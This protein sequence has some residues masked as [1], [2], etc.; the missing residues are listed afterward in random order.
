ML[1]EEFAIFKL[2]LSF[3]TDILLP[4]QVKTVQKAGS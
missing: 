3:W 4:E 2:K 1:V